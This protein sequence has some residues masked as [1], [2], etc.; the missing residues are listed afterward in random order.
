MKRPSKSHCSNGHQ[1]TE[2][3]TDW[4]PNGF[5][6]C[7]ACRRIRQNYYN[8]KRAGLDVEKPFKRLTDRIVDCLETDAGWLTVPGIALVLNANEENIQ[9]DLFRM[10]RRGLVESRLAYGTRLEWRVLIA[11]AA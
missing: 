3:N 9:R 10:K 6:S 11:V 4:H 7:G 2:A 1:Y 8:A 5:Y